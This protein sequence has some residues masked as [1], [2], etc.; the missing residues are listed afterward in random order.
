MEQTVLPTPVNSNS[1]VVVHNKYM[2][3]KEIYLSESKYLH[4][5]MA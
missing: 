5:I 3:P 1:D 2:E 4:T